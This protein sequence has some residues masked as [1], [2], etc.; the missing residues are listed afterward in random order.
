MWLTI[1]GGM[2]EGTREGTGHAFPYA[3]LDALLAEHGLAARSTV[4]QTEETPREE[5]VV[6]GHVGTEAAGYRWIEATCLETS[7][8]PVR[9][10]IVAYGLPD[11]DLEWRFVLEKDGQLGFSDFRDRTLRVRFR[12]AAAEER[13]ERAWRAAGGGD[14]T[15]G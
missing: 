2:L 5:R 8:I 6:R 13:F 10:E 12:S 4:D 9:A 15:Q 1:S 7:A 3:V 14:S 11:L